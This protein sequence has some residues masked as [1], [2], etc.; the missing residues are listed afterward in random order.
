MN[1]ACNEGVLLATVIHHGPDAGVYFPFY[2]GNGNVMGYVRGADGL[3]VV[4]YEYGPFGELLR[5]T[6]PLSQTFNPLFSTK[7]LDWETGLLYYGHRYY[8]PTTG[9]WPNR[10]PIQERGGLNLYGFVLNNPANYIDKHGLYNPITGPDGKPAGPGSGLPDPTIFLPPNLQ[11]PPSAPKPKSKCPCPFS[12]SKLGF[13][14]EAGG[15]LSAGAGMLLPVAG[16]GPSIGFE[17]SV[18]AM[19]TTECRFC[20]SAQV[21]FLLGV[22]VMGSASIGPGVS[23]SPRGLEGPGAGVGFGVSVGGV[24]GAPVGVTG[25][26]DVDLLNGGVAGAVTRL[27]PTIAIAAYGR[28]FVSCTGCADPLNGSWMERVLPQQVAQQR[29]LQCIAVN[30]AKL[31]REASQ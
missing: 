24:E 6:G 29:L 11:P 18:A 16:I 1:D 5:A 26:V 12:L 28:G 9:R 21:T 17:G 14:G 22:G 8:N 23:Y 19:V 25:A 27:G 3:L 15:G 30:V 20:I 2:D 10:D 7:Y 31:L 4:Q 13:P